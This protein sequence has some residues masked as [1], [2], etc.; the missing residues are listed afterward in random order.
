MLFLKTLGGLTASLQL[1]DKPTESLSQ[2]YQVAAVNYTSCT[3][4]KPNP[5]NP[6]C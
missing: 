4:T 6:V 2:S 5:A 3:L 1:M